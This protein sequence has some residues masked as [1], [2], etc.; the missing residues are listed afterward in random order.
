MF[1]EA[2][3]KFW[4]FIEA[5]ETPRYRCNSYDLCDLVSKAEWCIPF[6]GFMV[7]GELRESIN[8]LNAWM[9]Y[10][11]DLKVWLEVLKSYGEEDAWSL[12][13][14]FVE[15]LVRYCMLQPSSS[16]D[17]LGQVAAN[18]A[19]QANLCVDADYKDVLDQD[20][21]RPGQFMSRKKLEAQLARLLKAW[22]S[23]EQL[24]EAL[25]RMD[26]ETYRQ[27]TYDY[28]NEAS[29]FIAPRVEFGEVQFVKRRKI[30]FLEV[31]KQEDGTARLIK[32]LEKPRVAYVIG[33]IRPLTLA[34]IIEIN[35]QE[36]DFA[37]AALRTYS[38]LLREALPQ[39][40][41]RQKTREANASKQSENS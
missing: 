23:G 14:H 33:G 6:V 22:K 21:L 39:I 10:L 37:V 38:D 31:I 5:Q 29:H 27:Q 12:R 3:R 26:S 17:R 18:G 41:A 35:S 9:C 11:D 24:I 4:D 2:Y 8:E 20:K 16:R 34:E 36:Y 19:H 32:N 25:Q 30:P 15:P 13:V 1:E 28:R 7:D 40:A